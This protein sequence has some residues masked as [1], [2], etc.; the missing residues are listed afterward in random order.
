MPEH[1][2]M[3]WPEF[4]SQATEFEKHLSPVIQQWLV[5]SNAPFNSVG[6]P[7]RTHVLTWGAGS[8]KPV[9]ICAGGI[10]NTA[11]RFAILAQLL[12]EDFEC[13]SFDWYGRGHSDHLSDSQAYGFDTNVAQLQALLHQYDG[14]PIYFLGSSLGGM[15]GM[16]V[17]S[18]G[19][20]LLQSM[21]LNDVGPCM[22]SSR[23]QQRARALLKPRVFATPAQLRDKVGVAERNFGPMPALIQDYLAFKNT[24]WC[25]SSNGRIYRYDMAC[26][27]R[28]QQDSHRDVDLWDQWVQIECPQLLLHGALSDALLLP[29]VQRMQ[30][31]RPQ[32]EVLT[33]PNTGHTPSLCSAPQVQSIQQW[34]L[35]V[36]SHHMRYSTNSGKA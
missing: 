8:E 20:Y 32:L 31:A 3:S 25:K 21:I 27:S 13:V 11:F 12:Q 1:D 5:L 10:V 34:L 30:M 36:H 4:Y 28:F 18:E 2:L 9:L 6:K 15:V 7:A 22:E 19:Q 17:F 26:M 16:S 33:I 29:Q 24:R 23:R 14:R 35:K